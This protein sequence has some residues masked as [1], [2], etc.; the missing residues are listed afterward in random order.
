MVRYR[1]FMSTLFTGRPER[2]PSKP[3]MVI[4]NTLVYA[5][6]QLSFGIA[7]WYAEYLLSFYYLI[8]VPPS[9]NHKCPEKDRHTQSL[10][11]EERDSFMRI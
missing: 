8:P 9:T 5:N 3:L 4:L 1:V 11:Y 6:L 2:T 7:M 10:T